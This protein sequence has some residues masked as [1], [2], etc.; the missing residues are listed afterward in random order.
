MNK[1]K[2]RRVP[3]LLGVL[4]LLA[5]ALA[6]AVGYHM[7]N[8]QKQEWLL[9]GS[10][11]A[12]RNPGRGFYIQVDSARAGRLPDLAD[13][14]RVVLLA[15]D[16]RD[17]TDGPLP[18]AKLDELDDALRAADQAHLGV[19]FRA[20]YGF[21]ADVSEPGDLALVGTHIAQIAQVLGRWSSRLLVVQAGML[22][23]YGEWHDGLY[24][25]G[26]EALGR[27]ARLYVLQ[28]WENGL[29][30]GTQVAVRRPRF[31]REAPDAGILAGRLALHNDAL[32]STSSDMGTYDDP[33]YDFAREMAWMA[34]ALPG[35]CNGGEMPTLGERSQPGNAHW[36]FA[37]LHLS[38]L[39]LLYNQEVLDA[40]RQAPAPVADGE[41]SAFDY[42]E[43]HLGYRLWVARV[44]AGHQPLPCLA[45]QALDLGITLQNDG[46]A[47]LPAGYQVYLDWY[48]GTGALLQS[49]QLDR[50]PLDG[51]WG[52]GQATLRARVPLPD[53]YGDGPLV[54]GLRI[55]PDANTFDSL[56]CVELANGD[57]VLYLDGCNRLLRLYR[58]QGALFHPVRVDLW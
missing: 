51:A 49:T 11:R 13:Q 14:V 25:G 22:G 46:Y 23:D 3:A 30:Q 29:P 28:C 32:L 4:G 17:Y 54:L 21:T 9:T 38:Y 31:I 5:L 53:G 6:A 2:R 47:A 1:G 42:I 50:A 27:E 24:L 10:D 12:L 58:E 41:G 8:W 19:V 15:F 33:G 44:T 16:I 56:D 37:D 34:Q 20:A 35:V 7:L 18:Q 45:G 36:E 43:K 57:P 40:W 39:N 55:A 48:D 52:G 26:D